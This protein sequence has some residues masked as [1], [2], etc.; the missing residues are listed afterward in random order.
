MDMVLSYLLIALGV[1]TLTLGS[2]ALKGEDGK[3]VESR[4]FAA[5]AICSSIWSFFFGILLIQTEARMA[6][7]CR[8]AGM[9][10]TFGYLI[11][12]IYLLS[13]WG[14]FKKPIHM[15]VRL[16][17]LTAILLYPFLMNYDNVVYERADFGMSYTFVPNI[18]NSLYNGY[19]YI[20]A[21]CILYMGITMWRK[22]ERKRIRVLGRHM[23]ITLVV[24]FLG[25]LLDTVFPM[26][27]MGAFPGSSITQALGVM[28]SHKA[29]QFSRKNKVNITNM[30]EF[31][32]ST[33]ET[34]VLI[35]TE[36]GILEMAN[37]SAREFLGLPETDYGT[38]PLYQ[39]FELDK[40][41][42]KHSANEDKLKIDTNCLVRE[43]YCR[44]GI[45]T[46][47][48][49][50]KDVIGYIITVDDLTD[51]MQTIEELETARRRADMANQA[52]SAFL[53]KMSH[54][55]RTPINAILGM[56]EMI[57][58]ESD[59]EHISG[60]A[61]SIKQ[62]SKTLLSIV[63]DILDLSKI[64]S[65]KFTIISDKYNVPEMIVDLIDILS[66]K[67]EEKG[68]D[69]KI[70]LDE[71]IP[72]S[73]FG[74]ELRIKQIITNIMNNAIKY[75]EAGHV[76]L[77]ME[78]R[79][80][81]ESQG[82]LVIEITD[83]GIGI[84]KEDMKRL[85]DYYE[86]IDE[87]RNH[88]VEG[89][90]LGLTITKN[91]VE[92]MGGTL[93]A[94]SIYGKGSSF[95]VR[96]N[97]RVIDGTPMG[98]IEEVRKLRT[99]QKVEEELFIAPEAKILV[100]DDNMIN[101]TIMK[102]LLKRTEIQ[103]ELASSGELCLNM[104]RQKEYDIIFLDH[105]MPVMDGIETLKRMKQMPDNKS[106]NATVIVLT[107]NAIMGAKEMYLENGFHDYLSKP[108]DSIELEGAIR[109]YLSKEMILCAK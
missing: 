62:A 7:F 27:G 43:A 30:S 91:L 79:E 35:Y 82:E 85:F 70:E 13:H 68:L 76:L 97:Q 99:D 19:C 95:L 34:P 21:I 49:G 3:L 38:I 64:E 36:K 31:I 51:K 104:I 74:D 55:I 10:G 32:Y 12:A 56:D 29:L 106:K 40:D 98:A 44:L 8:C 100:V 45:N 63:N 53:A 61:V 50:Y 39:L 108:V 75:T 93:T 25:M 9:V 47:Y 58:R 84:R 52:K 71:N 80:T 37:N 16:F 28:I 96:V 67:V 5:L 14:N 103:V 89:T 46:I 59:E 11:S 60:Y 81:G 101:L 17:S 73:L 41:I 24:V 105:M 57:L 23:L 26:F 69:W 87:N 48:D 72:T 15:G 90:G 4:M 107:A 20:F 78:W 94:N 88:F 33:V 66:V 109:K 86:R 22:A 83:T 54:E 18:W 102:E 2:D 42:L 1:Y 6:Y 92:M 65:G 77:R